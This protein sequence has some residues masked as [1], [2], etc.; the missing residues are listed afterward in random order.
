MPVV[1][2]TASNKSGLL[3][4]ELDMAEATGHKVENVPNEE[5]K[6]AGASRNSV[7]NAESVESFD[8]SSSVDDDDDD[9][10]ARP[11]RLKLLALSE[12]LMRSPVRNQSQGKE[13]ASAASGGNVGLLE[14]AR[15]RWRGRK[16]RCVHWDKVEINGKEFPLQRADTSS[17]AQ[18]SATPNSTGGLAGAGRSANSASDSAPEK[19]EMSYLL[20]GHSTCDMCLMTFEASSVSGV[21]TMKRILDARRNWGMASSNAKKC[22][23]ASSLYG[24]ARLCVLCSQFFCSKDAE[25]RGGGEGS[26]LVPR[27]VGRSDEH[28]SLS[29]ESMASNKPLPDKTTMTT[30]AAAARAITSGVKSGGK[31]SAESSGGGRS[32][33]RRRRDGSGGSSDGTTT[34]ASSSCSGSRRGARHAGD[35]RVSALVP[36]FRLDEL[37]ADDHFVVEETDL[38][39]Q[40]GAVA[41]QSSTADGMGA[42]VCMGL[43][44]A[45]RLAAS[46]SAP[47]SLSPQRGTGAAEGGP[48]REYQ[49]APASLSP[50]ASTLLDPSIGTSGSLGGAPDSL[51]STSLR[52]HKTTAAAKRATA[53]VSLVVQALSSAKPGART[54]PSPQRMSADEIAAAEA[55]AARTCSRTRR[56]NQPWW[57]VDLG[58]AFPVRCIR[59]WH[60][61]RRTEATKAGASPFVDVSPFWI[62]TSAGAIGEAAPEEAR[63]LALSSKRVASHGKV[64]V[65]NLGVNHFATAVRV[66]AEGVKS[67][68]LARVE[69]IKGGGTQ[70]AKD[71]VQQQVGARND[72]S[73]CPPSH[74][75]RGPAD[76]SSSSLTPQGSTSTALTTRSAKSNN[77][78]ISSNSNNNSNTDDHTD[79]KTSLLRFYQQDR[80]V[81]G[82]GTAAAGGAAAAKTAIASSSSSSSNVNGLG[83]A[84]MIPTAAGA[85]PGAS[86]QAP[87][88]PQTCPVVNAGS[89]SVNG[90][91]C[92]TTGRRRRRRRQGKSVGLPGEDVRRLL[93]RAMV[94]YDWVDEFNSKD[95]RVRGAFTEQDVGVLEEIFFRCAFGDDVEARA[96]ATVTDQSLRLDPGELCADLR[97]LQLQVQTNTGGKG[98]TPMLLAVRE[99]PN[100]FQLFSSGVVEALPDALARAEAQLPPAQR[101]L[102]LDWTRFLGVM[103]LCLEGVYTGTGLLAP[104]AVALLF[105]EKLDDRLEFL[106]RRRSRLPPQRKTTKERTKNAKYRGFSGPGAPAGAAGAGAGAESDG[107]LGTSEMS[108]GGGGGGSGAAGAGSS[109]TTGSS[110]AEDASLREA[111]S[112]VDVGDDTLLESPIGGGS[113]GRDGTPATTHSA[114]DQDGGP[115]RFVGASGESRSRRGGGR[116]GGAVALKSL[117]RPQARLEVMKDYGESVCRRRER[118]R[119]ALRRAPEPDVEP[120][121]AYKPC[122]LCQ[123]PFPVESL[124]STV[125]LKVLG[126]FLAKAG[127]PSE[128]FDRKASRLCALHRLPLCVFCSQ[129]FDP[130]FPGGIVPPGVYAE[131]SDGGGGGGGGGGGPGGGR[132]TTTRR[133]TDRGGRTGCGVSLSSS[134]KSSS[135]ES[136]SLSSSSPS[137]SRPAPVEANCLVPFFDD[138]FPDRF[139]DTPPPSSA[140]AARVHSPPMPLRTMGKQEGHGDAAFSCGRKC[141]GVGGGAGSYGGGKRGMHHAR[142]AMELREV[143]G[144]VRRGCSI[145]DRLTAVPP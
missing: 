109:L 5:L 22:A 38:A 114:N 80:N 15:N 24:P 89:S 91:R 10:P 125:S 41:S 142:E 129:F 140:P 70:Q 123:A 115:S 118:Q 138:R 45:N 54:A 37:I 13:L 130:D 96:A 103:G 16:E 8:T 49:A 101:P 87:Y 85:A 43:P 98:K 132:R 131:R 84:P 61:D 135:L 83:A 27:G 4:V 139:S 25:G 77:N 11:H 3:R 106:T 60:P 33:R 92:A 141:D 71:A 99:S 55:A 119:E 144:L 107:D 7:A 69:V 64:T 20:V 9:K 44:A 35:R 94:G 120:T 79:V 90:G 102:G 28:V 111:G 21:I 2:R 108:P 126:T 59:V 78:N 116:G 46:R 88:R 128:R 57:E 95:V 97:R 48:T 30:A 81:N 53:T 127:A 134:S 42:D 76:T 86:N 137:R 136:P 75:R 47:P 105:E 113:R 52:S 31:P 39:R 112:S 19:P 82:D 32:C 36:N 68:Q 17:A 51:D 29:L 14:E 72:A 62:M 12:V 23:A 50:E 1:A 74:T 18:L 58:G 100:L 6:A 63:K 121:R 66:Q 143:G 56:E 40:Q 34:A 104:S 110:A 65:W 73:L 67:L 124:E 122:G 93:L 133:R 26:E 117:L 145:R